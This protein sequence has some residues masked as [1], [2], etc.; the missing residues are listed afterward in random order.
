MVWK[1]KISIRECKLNR[2]SKISKEHQFAQEKQS[3]S[4]FPHVQAGVFH[5]QSPSLWWFQ[6]AA[7]YGPRLDHVMTACI[8]FWD[9]HC[10][11]RNMV[12][13]TPPMGWEQVLTIAFHQQFM[14]LSGTHDTVHYSYAVLSFSMCAKF[15][16]CSSCL[17]NLKNLLYK[18]N[19]PDGWIL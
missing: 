7:T 5:M 14:L 4:S 3:A 1:R 17:I 8:L 12:K 18:S 6:G 9:R 11:H 15:H 16:V 19:L 2:D 10:F 13:T